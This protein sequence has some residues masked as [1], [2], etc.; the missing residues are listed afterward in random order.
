MYPY[1]VLRLLLAG[2]FLYM[3]WPH[4]PVAASAL[5]VM[6]WGGWLVFFLLTVGGNLA[7]LLQMISPP[8]MEQEETRRRLS[9]NH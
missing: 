2:F 7:A 8:V 3:A 1:V 9:D 6:F 5:E 4:I